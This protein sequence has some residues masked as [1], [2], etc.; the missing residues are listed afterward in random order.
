MV[1]ARERAV[2]VIAVSTGRNPGRNAAKPG[3]AIKASNAVLKAWSRVATRAAERL[4]SSSACKSG[5]GRRARA[6]ER[7]AVAWSRVVRK[8]ASRPASSRCRVSRSDRPS[9]ATAS[10]RSETASQ[11]SATTR[12]NGCCG[13]KGQSAICTSTPWAA[14]N[15]RG[16]KTAASRGGIER[17]RQPEQGEKNGS[18][19]ERRTVVRT[20]QQPPQAPQQ[21]DRGNRGNGR[22]QVLAAQAPQPA[23]SRHDH[24]HG[25]EQAEA[26]RV[27]SAHIHDRDVLRRDGCEGCLDGQVPVGCGDKRSRER[28]HGAQAPV[29]TRLQPPAF[30]KGARAD[31]KTAHAM[32]TV[33]TALGRHAFF[34][35][36]RSAR[37]QKKRPGGLFL[38]PTEVRLPRI[39]SFPPAPRADK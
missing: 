33:A 24:R 39:G 20:R 4:R 19:C 37:A 29:Q 2:L 22:R 14:A 26:E 15:G 6:A 10:S 5:R 8:A 25:Q 1:R 31:K 11:L 3:C 18:D 13:R 34:P 27:G 7:V 32:D 21:T 30:E 23:G 38:Q 28:H 17:N 12:R 16:E 35:R 36:G 9:G